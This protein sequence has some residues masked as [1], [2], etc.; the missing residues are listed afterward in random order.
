MDVLA[1]VHHRLVAL[2]DD[3]LVPELE[4]FD[5]RGLLLLALEHDVLLHREQLLLDGVD[6]GVDL[7]QHLRRLLDQR[8]GVG[9]EVRDAVALPGEHRRALLQLLID[10]VHLGLEHGL[11]NLLEG[12]HDVV[13]DIGQQVEVAHLL[14]ELLVHRVDVVGRLGHLELQQL[15]VLDLAQEL[16]QRRVE[17]DAQQRQALA[18]AVEAAVGVAHEQRLLELVLAHGLDR[19][20]P[21]PKLLLLV[22]VKELDREVVDLEDLLGLL[23]LHHSG[24]VQRL[25]ALVR[26]LD[27]LL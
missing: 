18:L 21:A 12:E 6:V 2:G 7:G 22:L 16:G 8:V 4:V 5:L 14:A 17:V 3:G 23:R 9:D 1:G 10:L 24:G 13:V 25:E 27:S 20:A 19:F 11:L 26:V 15:E